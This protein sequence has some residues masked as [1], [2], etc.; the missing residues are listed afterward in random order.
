MTKQ[1]AQR[2]YEKACRLAGLTIGQM[3]KAVRD[4]LS[5]NSEALLENPDFMDRFTAQDYVECAEFLAKR[6]IIKYCH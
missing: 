4:E 3:N 2:R 6:P 5:N 1:E